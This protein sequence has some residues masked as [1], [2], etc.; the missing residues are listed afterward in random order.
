MCSPIIY[1]NQ[2]YPIPLKFTMT[3][4]CPKELRTC[5]PA[6]K[7]KSCNYPFPPPGPVPCGN[8]PICPPNPCGNAPICP[9]PNP[10]ANPCAKPCPNPCNN[11]CIK[12]CSN[13]YQ[14]YLNLC[15]APNN[16][17]F[18]SIYIFQLTEV[19]ANNYTFTISTVD[20]TPIVIAHGTAYQIGNILFLTFLDD[21]NNFIGSGVIEFKNFN[22]CR[23]GIVN[24][25][26]CI[27]GVLSQCYI[28]NPTN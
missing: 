24:L 25:Q 13:P 5:F 28:V 18:P 23:Q 2:C 6:K 11:P 8:A 26:G 15:S 7:K 3:S 14:N 9:P 4:Y 21:N 1:N 20:S 27:K 17:M 16:W 22:Y 19:S 10:C 12:P